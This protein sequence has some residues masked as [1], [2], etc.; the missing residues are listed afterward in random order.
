M[1]KPRRRWVPA[2]LAIA[3]VLLALGLAG[4]LGAGWGF[5]LLI[6][7]GALLVAGTAMFAVFAFTKLGDTAAL[8]RSFGLLLRCGAAAYVLGVA[9]LSGHYVHE[10]LAGR[11][12]WHWI[13]FGPLALGALLAFDVG[14]K[15]KLV[16]GNVPTWRRYRQYISRAAIDTGALRS[17]F[18]DE[19]LVH[20][21]LFRVSKL[22][23]LR[24]ALIF[25]GFA[26]MFAVELAAVVV[27]EGFP[28]FGWRDL[29]REPGSALRFAFDFA[30]DFTGCMILAG[31]LLALAWRVAVNGKPERKYSDLPA[32][33][34]LL[35]VVVSGFMVE[36]FRIVASAGDPA[37]AFAFAGRATAA[38]LV[39]EPAT[40]AAWHAPLWVFH[41]AASC[42]LIALI[43]VL[44]L[45]HT[46]A[47]PL[48]RLMNS[49]QG[50]LAAKKRGVLTG[51]LGRRGMATPGIPQA[52]HR[53]G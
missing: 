41:A 51:M 13:I 37:H 45:V 14:L 46:C 43:P 24:H 8:E 53:T 9:A 34:F 39:V 6:A 50:M 15:R 27:R 1:G 30:Y 17:T 7:A 11:M 28:A 4:E 52:D 48:G 21:S 18:V 2:T 3:A 33:L 31:C 26:A 19:V 23:W 22:R 42:A 20:R 32:T 36:G 47:T 38:M 5:G 25:W 44:R 16:D 29:W 35:L 10:T 40:A 49:Q 12:E